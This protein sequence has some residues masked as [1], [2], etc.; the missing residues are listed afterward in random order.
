[1]GIGPKPQPKES[2]MILHNILRVP[3]FCLSPETRHIMSHLGHDACTQKIHIL[4]GQCDG[5]ESSTR[6][7]GI[8]S[9]CQFM[10]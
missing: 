10:V 4:G 1:M 5:T 9:E 7:A 2:K 8:P 3:M 6:G